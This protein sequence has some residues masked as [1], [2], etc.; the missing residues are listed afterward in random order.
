MIDAVAL[1]KALEEADKKYKEA[2]KNLQD[3][4]DDLTLIQK[5]AQEA[6]DAWLEFKRLSNE[7]A[8]YSIIKKMEDL[9]GC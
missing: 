1:K 6:N 9:Y 2:K 7:F 3:P 4:C 8:N 5:A